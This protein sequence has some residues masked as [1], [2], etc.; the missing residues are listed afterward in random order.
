MSYCLFFSQ[1]APC[2]AMTATW[3]PR[4]ASPVI[5]EPSSTPELALVDRDNKSMIKGM[6]VVGG[7]GGG[8]W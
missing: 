1:P 3:N 4:R 8:W 7:G 5:M 2:T 6:G